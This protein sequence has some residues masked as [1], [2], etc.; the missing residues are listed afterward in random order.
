M[1][2]A[3]C[4]TNN[5][6]K[7]RQ[8][9]KKAM[10]ILDQLEEAGDPLSAPEAAVVLA[11]ANEHECFAFTKQLYDERLFEH[12]A[13]GTVTYGLWY[14]Y[15][16]ALRKATALE[17]AIVA[18][19]EDWGV[20]PPWLRNDASARASPSKAWLT[21]PYNLLL[22]R[23]A[24]RR[25]SKENRRHMDVLAYMRRADVPRTVATYAIILRELAVLRTPSDLPWKVWQT[26]E[27]DG[28]EPQ[29]RTVELMAES[30]G[31]KVCMHDDCV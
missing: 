2:A 31:K 7:S 15:I 6:N 21:G 14:R 17:A 3:K 22:N 8:S 4:A 12:E 1:T 10:K 18:K 20:H 30:I 13:N 28:I 29:T 19:E 23:L 24:K 11:K 5:P 27:A 9:V 25:A 26:M 16:E